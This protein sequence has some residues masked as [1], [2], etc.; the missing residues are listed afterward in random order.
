[1][2]TNDQFKQG[3]AGSIGDLAKAGGNVTA[4]SIDAIKNGKLGF[5]SDLAKK[6]SA[7]EITGT[8]VTTG[9]IS[10]A[11]DGFTATASSGVESYTYALVGTWPAGI[12]VSSTTGA[13][14]GTPTESGAF[15]DLSVSVTDAWN[16]TAQ[17][18]TFTLTISA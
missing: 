7:V 17:L 13:V 5:W 8:P 2:P 3:G 10:V 4:L 14:S 11:Y 9:T 16:Q 12:T 15:T 18:D 1:M 6:V